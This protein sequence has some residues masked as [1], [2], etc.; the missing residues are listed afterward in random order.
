M[1]IGLIAVAL[2]V[3][4]K[5]GGVALVNYTL[6]FPQN[7]T[8]VNVTLPISPIP[9]TLEA[10]NDS[11]GSLIPMIL[12]S[13]SIVSLFLFGGGYVSL[14]YYGNYTFNSSNATYSISINSP[15]DI[16]LIIPPY[17]IPLN[18]PLTI[19]SYSMLSNNTLIVVLK[20]GNYTISYIYVP[21][22]AVKP[23]TTS[24]TTTTTTTVTATSSTS[25]TTTS[26]TSTAIISASTST[27]TTT[28][29]TSTTA[30]RT[31]TSSSPTST[32]TSSSIA[33]TTTTATTT[34]PGITFTY[35]YLIAVIVIVIAALS[36][37][38]IVHRKPG[39]V[40]AAGMYALDEVDRVI[41]NTL[42]RYGGVLY[43]SQLQQLTGIPKTTLWR[44]V[45]KLADMGIVR[46][47][48][49]DGL[50][51]VTLIKDV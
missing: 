31:T 24:S 26:T 44:H 5:E 8:V 18:L 34:P 51:R 35:I 4:F 42:K 25:T 41:V 45:M 50:N 37:I 13:R 10:I 29:T 22:I 32:T 43:Q 33:K 27:T 3:M 7:S 40:E 28:T 20:P 11:T 21:R 39:A 19:V 17:I 46:V 23:P 15:I 38:L 16:E 12:Y 9:D 6:Y 14:V 30:T 36:Y 2:I 1:Y 49:V 47:D 48:K